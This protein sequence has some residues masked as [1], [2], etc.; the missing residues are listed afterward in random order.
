MQPTGKPSAAGM[1]VARKS[2]YYL[3]TNHYSDDSYT[4]PCSRSLEQTDRRVGFA[5]QDMTMQV[6]NQEKMAKLHELND[7]KDAA[8]SLLGLLAEKHNCTVKDIYRL[9]NIVI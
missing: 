6:L 7:V 5:V 3:G 1:Y 8:D 9:L 2:F 4:S